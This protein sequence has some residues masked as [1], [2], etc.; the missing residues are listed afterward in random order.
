M[1]GQGFIGLDVA[2]DTFTAAFLIVDALSGQILHEQIATFSYDHPGW[3]RFLATWEPLHADFWW[4]GLEASGPYSALLEAHLLR[5]HRPNVSLHRLSPL[6][7]RDFARAR[8][9]RRTK[10]D[11]L[12]ACTIALFL[13]QP[14]TVQA[15]PAP[16]QDHT[17]LRALAHLDPHRAQ[18]L[19]RTQNQ[20]RQL[21]HFLFPE[22]ERAYARFPKA[23]RTLL[24]HFPSAPA[25]AQAPLQDLHA[26]LPPRHR[27]DLE[28]LQA[29]ARASFGLHDPIRAQTLPLLL[30][31]WAFLET[32]RARCFAALQQA[33][34]QHHPQAWRLLQTIPGIG[35]RLAALFLALT[36]PLDRF[37]DRKALIA[38]AGLDVTLHPS[39]RFAGRCRLSKRGDPLLRHVLY[40]IAA[41]LKRYTRRFAQAFA[42]YR[43]QGRAVRETLVILSRK[44]LGMLDH[45]LRH[46]VLFQDLPQP[47]PV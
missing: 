18:E 19:T 24:R 39:G 29:L 26:L 21:L 45:L 27:L 14:L 23:L 40:L 15:L 12:D 46:Q 5:L 7:V 17:P 25:I 6:Q 4:I 22:L 13:R 10:T 41:A 42:Y 34:R 35:P 36:G 2:K 37:P 8:S 43:H 44:A 11:R 16:L 30:D 20:V 32:L 38:D 47:A 33:V 3:Q 31:R 9:R 28:A 1:P